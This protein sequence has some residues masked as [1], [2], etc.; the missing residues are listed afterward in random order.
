VRAFASRGGRR[1]W[2]ANAHRGHKVRL[3]ALQLVVGWHTG[4]M[5]SVATLGSEKYVSLVT[6]KKNGDTVATP[7]WIVDLG[8]GT[9]GFTTDLTSGKVK[10][11][12]NFPDVTL[13]PCSQRGAIKPGSSP[14]SATATVLTGADIA[15]VKAAVSAKYGFMVKL[16]GVGYAIGRIVKRT[17]ASPPA[18]IRLTLN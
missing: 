15:P 17:P 12:R 14:V 8:D 1:W 18:A 11:I 10:R 13:Q 3:A 7:V 6:R 4:A 9:L 2:D 5:S 16:V